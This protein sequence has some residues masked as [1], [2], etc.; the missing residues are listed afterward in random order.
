[1]RVLIVDDDPQLRRVLIRLVESIG[2]SAV[3]CAS[4]AEAKAAMALVP[5]GF[6]LTDYDLGHG[7]DLDSG[8][9]LVSWALSLGAS[10][11]FCFCTGSPD[12]KLA[13]WAA[14]HHIPVL[15]KPFTVEELEQAIGT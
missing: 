7:A 14:S 8:I 11:R 5:F 2:H 12:R 1:M 13:E 6:V 4:I 10:A 3:A 15:A 9:D